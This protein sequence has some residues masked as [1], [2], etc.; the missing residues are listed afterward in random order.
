MGLFDRLRSARMGEPVRGT[1]QVVAASGYQGDAVWQS[2]QL[3]LVVSAD[4]VPP[5]AVEWSGLA[6]GKKWPHAGMVLPVTV[7]RGDPRSLKIEWDEVP[8]AAD[9]ARQSAEDLAAM[10]RGEGTGAGAFGGV[11][12]QVINLS[13]GDLADLSDDQKA[14]LRALGIDPGQLADAVGGAAAASPDPVA[15]AA[16]EVEDQVAL[17]ERLAKLHEQGVLTDEELRE[18]KARILGE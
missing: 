6:R 2:C 4:G 8:D 14:K 17:L 9:V 12:A 1:A 13:G 16:D 5:T 3:S 11:G 15:D 18:Q 7:D 10:M